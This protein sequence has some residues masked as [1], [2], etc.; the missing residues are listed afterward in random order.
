MLHGC[1]ADP[2]G[3]TVAFV[4]EQLLAEVTGDA[5]RIDVIAERGPADLDR[6]TP[7]VYDDVAPERYPWAKLTLEAHLIKLER[8]AKVRAVAGQWQRNFD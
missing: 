3:L 4:N 6:L 2:A 5:L 8:E 7:A 1:A